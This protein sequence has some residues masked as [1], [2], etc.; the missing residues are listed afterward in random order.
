MINMKNIIF[1]YIEPNLWYHIANISY[2]LYSGN[3]IDNASFKEWFKQ[4][5]VEMRRSNIAR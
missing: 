4:V 3:V 2:N 1:E 5:K